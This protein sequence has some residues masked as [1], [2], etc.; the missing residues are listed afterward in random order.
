MSPALR[1]I[2]APGLPEGAPLGFAAERDNRA[3]GQRRRRLSND[4]DQ[5][6]R[7]LDSDLKKNTNAG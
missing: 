1:V 5:A 3:T 7:A 2:V 6:R 4:K